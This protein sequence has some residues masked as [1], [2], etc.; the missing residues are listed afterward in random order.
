MQGVLMIS[1]GLTVSVPKRLIHR[2]MTGA[3]GRSIGNP[4]QLTVCLAHQLRVGCIVFHFDVFGNTL[5]NPLCGVV[6]AL[7]V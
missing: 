3:P 6:S 5:G 1:V 2:P 4:V 7:C